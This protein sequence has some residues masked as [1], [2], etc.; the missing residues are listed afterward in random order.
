MAKQKHLPQ[1][2]LCVYTHLCTRAGAPGCTRI[3]VPMQEP[4]V[5][6]PGGAVLGDRTALGSISVSSHHTVR[7]SPNL[8]A[9]QI[10]ETE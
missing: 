9:P 5:Q 1:T 4:L 10:S 2:Q 8:E 7:Q 3:C 6:M